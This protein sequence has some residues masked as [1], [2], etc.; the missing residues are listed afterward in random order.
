MINENK[1][2]INRKSRVAIKQRVSEN[3]KNGFK[4][5]YPNSLNNRNS[6]LKKGEKGKKIIENG[7]KFTIHMKILEPLENLGWYKLEYTNNALNMLEK[8]F[9]RLHKER[10]H[11][12]FD[13]TSVNEKR[14]GGSI[15]PNKS[16]NPL[17]QFETLV[18]QILVERNKKTG[19]VI[20]M[21]LTDF[22]KHNTPNHTPKE[23]KKLEKILVDEFIRTI[24]KNNSPVK[25]LR[26][27]NTIGYNSNSFQT[28]PRKSSSQF[29]PNSKSTA[30]MLVWNI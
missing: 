14:R 12:D 18:R 19:K 8:Q 10:P 16:K 11:T 4:L 29:S 13:V 27:N 6:L 20:K 23:R 25:R 3:E 5:V 28:P 15:A 17:K 2:I 9:K 30:R 21:Y 26:V 22:E 7:D 1:V 24:K